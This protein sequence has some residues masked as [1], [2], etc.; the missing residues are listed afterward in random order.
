MKILVS[1]FHF[2]GHLVHGNVK[3]RKRNIHVYYTYSN[4]QINEKFHFP[5]P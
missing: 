5:P 2:S 1:Q 4:N 3:L